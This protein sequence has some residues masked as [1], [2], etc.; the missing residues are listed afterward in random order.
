MEKGKA[1]ERQTGIFHLAIMEE[2]VNE[3]FK[4]IWR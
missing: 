2:T 1:L 4:I 3:Y